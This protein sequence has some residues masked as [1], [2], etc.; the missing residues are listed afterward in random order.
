MKQ[1][2]GFDGLSFD[3]VSVL[4]D[5]LADD[6]QLRGGIDHFLALPLGHCCAIPE[7]AVGNK[8]A[9][10]SALDKKMLSSISSPFFAYWVF[11]SIVG[12]G[13]AFRASPK[14]PVAPYKS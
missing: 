1:A 3:P 4:Q 14:T 10:P 5:G 13:S 8:P 11:T 7:R 9:L 2:P 6:A 12:S